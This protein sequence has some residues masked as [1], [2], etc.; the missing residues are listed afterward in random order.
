LTAALVVLI[1]LLLVPGLLAARAPLPSVPALSASFWILSSWWL[2]ATV[3]RERFVRAILV[4]GLLALVRL[5]DVPRRRPP[6]RAVA[7]TA[8]AVL[9]LGLAF[10]LEPAAAS[11]SSISATLVVWNDGIPSS[12]QPLLDLAPFGADAPSLATLSADVALLSGLS[13]PRAVLLVGLAAS[14]LLFLGVLELRRAP[15]R[16]AATPALLAGAAALLAGLVL[17]VE[18]TV[19]A[20]A[21]A[22]SSYAILLGGD[23][24]LRSFA[25]T[26][27]L[28]A[29]FLSQS[30]V[31]LVALLTLVVLLRPW[32][33]L[34]SRNRAILTLGLALVLAAPQIQR[35]GSAFSLGDLPFVLFR[36]RPCPNLPWIYQ[37]EASK[38]IHPCALTLFDKLLGNPDLSRSY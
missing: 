34:A 33:S 38:S 7:L 17:H 4:G 6:L 2:P 9:P 26:L 3:G 31:G 14:C 19:L 18:S 27:I 30:L 35:L 13:P 11:F 36:S 23:S 8:A 16:R 10:V 28:A 32:A 24:V 1:A 25:A 15:A 37:Q 12:F 20:V 29:S 5:R 21:L 22:L